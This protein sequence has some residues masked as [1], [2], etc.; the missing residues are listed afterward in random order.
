MNPKSRAVEF[1]F[2]Y[3]NEK[4]KD[5]IENN[6]NLIQNNKK[7]ITFIDTINNEK[8]EYLNYAGGLDEE[9]LKNGFGILHLT[10]GSYFKGMFSH[11][12]ANGFGIFSHSKGDIYK[13]EFNNDEISGYGEYHFQNISVTSGLWERS[14]LG[15][16][17]IELWKQSS[18]YGEFK[19]DKNKELE[20]IFGKIKL[21]MMVNGKMIL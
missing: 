14:I 2:G 15:G 11:G 9:N 4:G 20:D 10:D 8:V 16:I 3:Y 5:T 18:Y 1:N 19:M 17:G 13:G 7:P 21:D 12:H 6:N